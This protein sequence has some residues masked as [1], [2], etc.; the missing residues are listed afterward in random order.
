MISEEDAKLFDSLP[1]AGIAG[2]LRPRSKSSARFYY[3][4]NRCLDMMP[5]VLDAL[6]RGLGPALILL[7]WGLFGTCAF[8]FFYSIVP[9]HGWSFGTWPGCVIIPYG[10]FL[11]FHVYYNHIFASFVSPGGRPK[12]WVVPDDIEERI[13]HE[14]ET[15]VRGEGFTKYC[16]TCV[17]LK[18]PRMHHW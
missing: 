2:R 9:V 18:A 8:V 10:L 3:H 14:K 4:I 6:M 5:N 13:R 11:L 15:V 12:D 16:K 1:Q 17:H 7:A